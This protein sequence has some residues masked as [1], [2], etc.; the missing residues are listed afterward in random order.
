MRDAAAKGPARVVAIKLGSLCL[1]GR[2]EQL[3][4]WRHTQTH[5]AFSVHKE[6]E[7]ELGTL[8]S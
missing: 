8:A 5:E 4:L 6:E 3:E 1:L 2:S 7:E